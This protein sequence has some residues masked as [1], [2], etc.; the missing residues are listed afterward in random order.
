MN[1]VSMTESATTGAATTWTRVANAWDGNADFVERIKEPVTARLLELV[2]VRPGDRVLELGAGPGLLGERLAELTGQAG[3]V[4]VSDI[5][6]GMVGVAARRLAG[7]D[8]VEVAQL[9]ATATGLPAASQDVV[10][11]RMGLMLVED[12]TSAATE[13][14]RILAPGGRVGVAVWAGLEHNPWLANVGMAAMLSGLVTGGPPIGPGGVFSLASPDVLRS[15]IEAAGFRDVAVETADITVPFAGLDDWLSYVRS[16]AGPLVDA[17]ATASPDQ[18]DAVRTTVAQLAAP[19]A[20][21]RGG[22]ELP[23]RA[24]IVVAKR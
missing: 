16:M 7:I 8:N 21:S 4:V 19:F 15:T 11:F 1:D 13:I 10:V 24:N 18:L 22:Y 17:F 23:G 3:R 9:D 2:D 20:T 5:A 12:P 6:P 14:A